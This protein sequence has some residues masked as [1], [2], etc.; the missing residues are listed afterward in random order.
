MGKRTKVFVLFTEKGKNKYSCN[1]CKKEI[2]SDDAY[3]LK[4][5]IENSCKNKEAKEAW[6]K[7]NA[8]D[9]NPLKRKKEDF[10]TPRVSLT[11]AS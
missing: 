8:T 1:F 2:N 9:E 6:L 10:F 4:R 5:H 11:P 7:L 3:N